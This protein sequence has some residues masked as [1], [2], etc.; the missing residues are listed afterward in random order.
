MITGTD[1]ENVVRGIPLAGVLDVVDVGSELC[2]PE[3][4]TDRPGRGSPQ[5]V[6]EIEVVMGKNSFLCGARD[7]ECSLAD[8]VLPC[9]G[10]IEAV[11]VVALPLQEY[12]PPNETVFLFVVNINLP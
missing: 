10:E 7:L 4:H 3:R 12:Y 2:D 5:E 6:A 1:R 8:R 9:P 11:G